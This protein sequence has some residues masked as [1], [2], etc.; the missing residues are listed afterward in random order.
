[1]NNQ[2][3]EVFKVMGKEGYLPLSGQVKELNI[4]MGNMKSY[5]HN[6]FDNIIIYI[7]RGNGKQH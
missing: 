2:Y 3:E 5:Y 1:M 6:K 4:H 7:Y